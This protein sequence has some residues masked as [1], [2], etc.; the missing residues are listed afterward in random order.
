[1]F[2]GADLVRIRGNDRTVFS[3][4][5]ELSHGLATRGWSVS[6]VKTEAIAFGRDRQLTALQL[7]RCLSRNTTSSSTS[8]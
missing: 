8:L 3:P 4:L 6:Y 2:N 5:L 7:T 1:M